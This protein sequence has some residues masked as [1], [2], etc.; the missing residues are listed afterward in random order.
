MTI[1]KFLNLESKTVTSAA[2]ILGVS[3]LLS[4]VLGLFRDRILA[5]TFGAGD[6]LDAYY[7]SFRIPDFIYNIIV[8]GAISAGFIPIFVKYLAKDNKEGWKLANDVLNSILL[9]LG[10]FSLILLIFSPE[11]VK[12]LAPGFGPEKLKM[13]LRFSQVML[14]SP[15][16]LGL[17]SVVSSILQSQKRFVW[18]SLSPIFYNLGII[19]GASVLTRFMGPIGLAAGVAM[20]S[21]LHLIVQL[22]GL[23]GSGFFYRPSL[24]FKNKGVWELW[25]M[26]IPRTLTLGIN[27]LA[28]LVAT[29]FA[30]GLA[31]GSL[32]VFSLANNLINLPVGIFG[33]SYALAVFPVL[34]Q[35]NADK[36]FDEY[37]NQ[38]SGTIRQVM[39]FMIPFT[40]FFILLR[41]Q[42]VRIALGSGQFNWNDTVMTMQTLGFFAIGLLAFSLL[43]TLVRAFYALEDSRTPLITCAVTTVL[44]FVLIWMFIGQL[45][46]VGLALAFSVDSIAEMVLL[47]I[48]LRIRLGPINEKDIIFSGSKIITASLLMALA[49]QGVKYFVA[50]H[51]N[52]QSFFGIF[53]QGSLAGLIGF[54][55]FL[56]S[57]WALGSPEMVLLIES[58]RRQFLRIAR[59]NRPVN[60]EA[61]EE[62]VLK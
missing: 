39:F 56:I 33:I 52:F 30:S 31:S 6:I 59:T 7:A 21:A 60:S 12:W 53:I 25:Q 38:L 19:F 46:V 43:P 51:L 11:L 3:S 18:Y 32:S 49:I 48:I 24:P 36:K 28:L 41:A 44:N 5:G 55:V 29:F 47:Y 22:P 9:S 35:A 14:L 2:V 15:I 37:R 1:N 27:Q 61:D 62:E 40:V 26:T 8:L 20:G 17:S 54:G 13:T 42:I 16:F 4:R 50:P 58:S 23:F 34:S 45:Q 10:V 57:A